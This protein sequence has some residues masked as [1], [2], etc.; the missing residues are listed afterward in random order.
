MLLYTKGMF[1]DVMLKEE[2][3]IKAR[4]KAIAKVKK[5]LG[6]ITF[7][8]VTGG[9]FYWFLCNASDCIL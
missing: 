7:S 8:I 4:E 1:E 9:F 6:V 2:R 5:V 3:K